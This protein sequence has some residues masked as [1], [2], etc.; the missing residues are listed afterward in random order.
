MK[1]TQEKKVKHKKLDSVFADLF[2]IEENQLKLYKA[3]LGDKAREDISS[4][5][6][7]LLNIEKVFVN[8]LYNDLS[9]IVD[10]ELMILVEAQ[11]R[12]TK[13]IVTRLL[14]YLSRTLEKYIRESNSDNKLLKLYNKGEVKI[15]SIKLYTIYTEPTAMEDHYISLK[16]LMKDTGIESDIDLRVKIIC[17]P[18]NDNI[19]GQYISFC[20]V[21]REQLAI[22]EDGEDAIS[23]TIRLCEN[24]D[25][26][27][28][29]LKERKYEVIEMLAHLVT[30]EDW[31]EHKYKEGK[32]EG[33]VFGLLMAGLSD[34]EVIKKANI[35][36]EELAKYKEELKD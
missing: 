7:N 23:E 6:I 2:S 24:K 28:E 11:S 22:C 32:A 10:D 30:T 29:Y 5:D 19:L 31:M 34:E 1:R 16:E 12:Y 17:V 27:K 14:F 9:L 21:L 3:L 4:D 25:I 26:L 18:D 13:N 35:T 15:P 20:R 33:I 8:D 36:S